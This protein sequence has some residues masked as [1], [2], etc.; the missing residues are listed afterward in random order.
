M[1]WDIPGSGVSAL[2]FAI[3]QRRA[4]LD[5]RALLAALHESAMPIVWYDERTPSD[6]SRWIAHPQ[7]LTPSQ[8]AG[9]GARQRVPHVKHGGMVC[10]YC[11][12]Q[13]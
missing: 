10:A 8:C 9:C 6:V 3:E 2:T 13:A 11:G 12:A 4:L 7:A 1:I 5:Q